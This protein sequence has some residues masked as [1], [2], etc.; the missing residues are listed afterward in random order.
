MKSKNFFVA[1]DHMEDQEIFQFLDQYQNMIGGVKI[2]LEN[3]CR[4]G[5]ELLWKIKRNYQLPLFLDLKLHDIP[6]TIKGTLTVLKDLPIDYLTLHVSGGSNMLTTAKDYLQS[7]QSPI[8]IL[9]VTLLTSLDPLDFKQLWN[10][11]PKERQ[12]LF[13]AYFQL[14][15]QANLAGMVLS[16]EDLPY[17]HAFAK[18]HG[19][20]AENG[21]V[22]FCPGIRFA[23]DPHQDQKRVLTPSEAWNS[24]AHQLVI[25]RSLTKAIDKKERLLTLQR[26]L[27]TV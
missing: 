2:G 1:F 12:S 24:G 19:L 5:H 14:V 27:S 23:S 11:G 7:I 21:P 4:Y 22:I 25:G 20:T 13:H 18:D 10:V 9:G 26:I 6:A 17:Y 3:F 8:K 16:A 15:L